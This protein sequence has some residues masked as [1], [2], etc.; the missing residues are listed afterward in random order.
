MNLKRQ[1]FLGSLWSLAGGG[2]QPFVSLIIFVYIARKLTPADVGIVALAMVF[3][4]VLSF[5]ARWGQV[6]TLQRQPDVSDREMST[7]FWILAGGGLVV[8]GIVAA[9]AE[10]LESISGQALLGTVL[11]LLTPI[12]ATQALSAVPEAILRRRFSYRSLAF[13]TWIATLAGGAAGAGLAYAGYGVY[14][15]V[16]QRLVMALVG[17][18]TS[19]AFLRW[20]PRM[21]FDKGVASVLVRTGSAIMGA[22]FAG[23][24]NQRTIESIV[25]FMLGPTELGIF[26]VG[27]RIFEPIRLLAVQPLSSVGLSMFSRLQHDSAALTRAY[28]RMTQFMALASLPMYLGLSAVSHVL[29]PLLLGT[30]WVGVVL[31]LQLGCFARIGSSVNDFFAAAMIATGRSRTVLRQATFHLALIAALTFVGSL[32]GLIGVLIALIVRSIVISAYNLYTL[33]REGGIEA[34]ALLRAWAPAATAAAVMFVVV[35]L[36]SARLTGTLDGL[37]LLVTLIAIGAA[38]YGAALGLGDL[39][40]LWRGYIL[41]AA[42]SLSRAAR[43]QPEP[44]ATT[45]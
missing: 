15:L 43:R 3:I 8:T 24:F 9:G 45:A 21:S 26:R 42:A 2:A 37:P 28:L 25:G 33:Q 18:V 19:W 4:D 39:V 22:S 11:L 44:E 6:E 13:R 32:F 1:V 5:V 17:L 30:K 27:S 20:R 36:A 12:L 10:A 31:V 7:A 40:G 16:A 29:V 23:A 41:D 38:T 14:A 35:E 34:A